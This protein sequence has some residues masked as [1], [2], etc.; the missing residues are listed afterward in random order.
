MKKFFTTFLAVVLAI[1][2]F[3]TM[4]LAADVSVKLDGKTLAFE[5]PPVII[6]GRTLVPLRAIFEAL[7]ATVEWDGATKTVT[8]SKGDVTVKLAIGSN[9]LYK[10]G[11]GVELDVP[12]QIVGAGYTMVPARAVAESF[13]VE[14]GWDDAT[15]TVL[16]TSPAVV[17]PSGNAPA[18]LES[19]FALVDAD[20]FDG[21]T[22][23]YPTGTVSSSF[24]IT[25]DPME[26]KGKVFFLETDI[27]ER[28]SW[29][30]FK[31][32]VPIKDNQKYA[33]EF[34]VLLFEL[35]SHGT[36]AKN[37]SFGL[38]FRYYDTVEGK[39]MDHSFGQKVVTPGEWVHVSFIKTATAVDETQDTM[40]GLFSTPSS[41]HCY[42]YYLDNISVRPYNGDLRDGFAD[43]AEL[44][45]SFAA[46]E[47]LQSF[48]IDKLEGIIYDFETP[49]DLLGFVP[50]ERFAPVVA[51]GALNLT[52]T[53]ES[54]KDVMFGQNVDFAASDY[55]KVAIKLKCDNVAAFK[56]ASATVFFATDSD[57]KPNQAKSV[58]AGIAGGKMLADGYYV[59]VLDV[60][61]NSKWTGKITYLRVDPME[62]P[63]GT[64]SID[65]IVV[66]K[67]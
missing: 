35:D 66:Y 12:A 13:G 44:A 14:V 27:T 49:G 38:N 1:T 21:D 53:E 65:K 3:A 30:Y 16:L 32:D 47:K 4:A 55:N 50:S 29:T 52:C 46:L 42:S 63:L 17:A 5:Q 37:C 39:A 59:V 15:K 8:S 54:G 6:E 51:N 10:N 24:V 28:N 58:S 2:C 40:F 23:F 9:V 67:D 33:I 19:G 36:P 34:D 60:G 11:E 7:G 26:E 45:A 18:A 56:T 64:V 48:D 43:P 22:K 41:T 25:D 20:T 31:A 62:G 57:A 61:G